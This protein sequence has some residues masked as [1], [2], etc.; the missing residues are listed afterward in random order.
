LARHLARIVLLAA[1]QDLSHPEDVLGPLRRRDRA[2]AT[3]GAHRG[4]HGALRV[5]GGGILEQADHIAAIGGAAILEHRR[6]ARFDPFPV[7]EVAVGL[8]L[9]HLWRLAPEL[10]PEDGSPLMPI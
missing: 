4:V 5:G 7:D 1:H 2:P 9:G 10:P 6:R 3:E 8:W